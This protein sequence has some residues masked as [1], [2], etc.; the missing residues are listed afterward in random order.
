[1]EIIRSLEEMIAALQKAQRDAQ[2][3]GGGGG[4]GGGD[5]DQPLVD[6]I[7]E[8]KMIRALQMRV[9]LRTQ[10]YHKLLKDP[11]LEQADKP[12]VIEALQRLGQREERIHETTRN[13]V[14]GKTE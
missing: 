2:A 5:E 13:I 12:D 3:G 4:G 8:L 11:E 6:K 7:A 14:V 9:N 1:V 10:R